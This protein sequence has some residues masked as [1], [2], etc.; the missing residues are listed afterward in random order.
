MVSAG[1]DVVAVR[2]ADGRLS[3]VKFGSDNPVLYANGLAADGDARL[4]NGSRSGGGICVRT[5]T[6]AWRGLRTVPPWR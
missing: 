6:G 5:P 2:G 1:G 4:P 3:A